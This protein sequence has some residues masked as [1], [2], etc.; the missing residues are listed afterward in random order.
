MS[1]INVSLEF[2]IIRDKDHAIVLSR[3]IVRDVEC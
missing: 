2:M 3:I 1:Y